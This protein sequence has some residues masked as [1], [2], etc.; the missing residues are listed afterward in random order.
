[1]KYFDMLKWF[2]SLK[3]GKGGEPQNKEEAINASKTQ[4][5]IRF[6]GTGMIKIV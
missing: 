6:G 3:K 5:N 1:M 4:E 2:K